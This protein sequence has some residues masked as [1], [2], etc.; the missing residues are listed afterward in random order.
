MMENN[1]EPKGHLPSIWEK[2]DLR[3][4]KKDSAEAGDYGRQHGQIRQKIS[5]RLTSLLAHVLS[6]RRTFSLFTPRLKMPE[7]DHHAVFTERRP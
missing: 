3:V 4:A 5:T 7:A 6:S 2:E 1:I